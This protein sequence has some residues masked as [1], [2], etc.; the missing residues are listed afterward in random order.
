V[1]PWYLRRDHINLL[2]DDGMNAYLTS[3]GASGYALLPVLYH[4]NNYGFDLT[5][6]IGNGDDNYY[7]H[8]AW[9]APAVVRWWS[10]F[11]ENGQLHEWA[12]QDLKLIEE[13]SYS[14]AGP[15]VAIRGDSMWFGMQHGHSW[16]APQL[17]NMSYPE[18]YLAY[19]SS[20]MRQEIDHLTGYVPAYRLTPLSDEAQRGISNNIHIA[21]LVNRSPWTLLVQ[22]DTW[23]SWIEEE[24]EHTVGTELAGCHCPMETVDV[25]SQVKIGDVIHHTVSRVEDIRCNFTKHCP[26]NWPYDKET[27]EC[28]SDEERYFLSYL[29][30]KDAI[31]DGLFTVK[32]HILEAPFHYVWDYTVHRYL[33]G[34]HDLYNL[35]QDESMNGEDQA[36]FISLWQQQSPYRDLRLL[37]THLLKQSELLTSS[38]KQQE[39]SHVS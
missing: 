13:E 22:D 35:T 25:T 33:T 1:N 32:E 3:P 28:G 19:E 30:L 23:N 10:V 11:D 26:C 4:Q 38:R 17:V 2:P 7:F 21:D 37:Q 20:M 14:I 31:Y 24:K 29:G 34:L 6:V 36:W 9:F 18:P 15:P 39:F 8:E 27:C 16:E 12:R 5:V